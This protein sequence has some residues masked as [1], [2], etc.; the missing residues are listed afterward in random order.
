MLFYFISRVSM[1]VI[2]DIRWFTPEKRERTLLQNCSFVKS[3]VRVRKGSFCETRLGLL[4]SGVPRVV[5]GHLSPLPPC[6][7]PIA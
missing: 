7:A 2:S 5:C 6:Q 3:P 4:F 1:I